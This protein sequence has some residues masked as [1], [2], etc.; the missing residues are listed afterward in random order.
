MHILRMAFRSY[1]SERRMLFDYQLVGPKRRVTH[2]ICPGSMTAT[3]ELK[4]AMLPGLLEIM[5]TGI[6]TSLTT[7]VDD[8][9]V[10]VH[11]D[12]EQEALQKIAEVGQAL[13]NMVDKLGMAQAP[14]KE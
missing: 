2:G 4:L 12:S 9:R 3:R 13:H 7:H 8:I 10:E 11:G 1:S 14:D 6:P 5:A